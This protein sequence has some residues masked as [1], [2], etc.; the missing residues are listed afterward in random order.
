M[1]PVKQQ[2]SWITRPIHHPQL[3]TTVTSFW[4][5]NL[6]GLRATRYWD[7]ERLRTGAV[8][9]VGNVS[10]TGNSPA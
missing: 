5:M 7:A 9:V 10:Y 6:T 2:F 1:E 4:Q 3:L 8:A